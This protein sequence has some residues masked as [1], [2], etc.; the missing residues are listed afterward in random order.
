MRKVYVELK[1]TLV[2]EVE[3][4]VSVDEIISDMDYNF[5]Y[6]EPDYGEIVDNYLM[7]WEIVDSK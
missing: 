2:I 4:G 7:D 6:R 1:A 3:E 5:E